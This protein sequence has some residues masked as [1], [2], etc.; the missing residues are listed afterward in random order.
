[1]ADEPK[2]SKLSLGKRPP[3]AGAAARSLKSPKPKPKQVLTLDEAMEQLAALDAAV[4][5][6]VDRMAAITEIRARLDEHEERG[7]EDPAEAMERRLLLLKTW[8]ELVKM[9]VVNVQREA[10]P[11]FEKP[12][13]ERMFVPA[14]VEP[15]E[16]EPTPAPEPVVEAPKPALKPLKPKPLPKE[17]V[18]PEPVAVADDDLVSVKL[19]A[20]ETVRGIRLEAGMVVAVQ[21]DD[22]K[23]L[24]EKGKAVR[25]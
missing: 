17:D 15:K 19:L 11:P 2:K 6:E 18:P 12:K 20:S 22:A 23:N 3:G 25:A 16:V 8:N 1:M 21:P 5:T 13:I 7:E 10:P 4:M 14:E 9:R 24:I